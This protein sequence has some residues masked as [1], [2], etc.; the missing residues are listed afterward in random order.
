[1]GCASPTSAPH[2]K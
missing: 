2:A 1:M